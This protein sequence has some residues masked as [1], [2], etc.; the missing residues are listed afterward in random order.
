[1]TLESI[2]THN[3]ILKIENLSS[4]IYHSEA[5]TYFISLSP[6]FLRSMVYETNT[7]SPHDRLSSILPRQY[8]SFAQEVATHFVSVKGWL[9]EL[10]ISEILCQTLIWIQ[11]LLWPHNCL[12]VL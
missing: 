10:Y 2:I 6:G 5:T 11:F 1:M 8:G 9:L 12:L 4:K 7:A 3:S